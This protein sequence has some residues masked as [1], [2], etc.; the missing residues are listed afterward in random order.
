MRVSQPDRYLL[1]KFV[2][3]N[4][5]LLQGSLLDVGGQDGKRYRRYFPHITKH[6]VLDPDASAKPDI[7]SGAEKMPLADASFD[8][9]LCMEVLMDIYDVHAAVKEM[10]RVLKPGG[11]LLASVSFMSPLC[12]EPYHFWRFT[13][14]SLRNLFA[15]DFTDIRIEHRGGYRTERAQ[16]WIRY[17]I[18]RLDLYKKP[19]LGRLFSLVS[20]ARGHLAMTLDQH[21]RSA[22]N[23]KF[24]LGFNVVAK[25]K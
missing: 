16:N 4:S 6:T 2:E 14:H 18:E 13:P 24:A 1:A 7:V 22:A 12:D 11:H 3:Q 21:D 20:M 23:K 19:L 25:R 15:N 5:P 9:E 17:W 8:S 10:A